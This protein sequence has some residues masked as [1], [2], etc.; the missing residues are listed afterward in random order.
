MEELKEKIAILASE[1]LDRA[2]SIKPLFV[3]M[4][5]GHNVIREEIEEVEDE[6]EMINISF[7]QLWQYVKSDNEKWGL[8]AVENIMDSA[9]NA[10]AELVQVAAMCQKFKNS[11]QGGE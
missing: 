5:Q 11:L 10:A 6:I 8:L 4:H 7:N 2:M 9:I 1:E 3:D